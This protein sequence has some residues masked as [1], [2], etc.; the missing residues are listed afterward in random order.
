MSGLDYDTLT[1]G[2]A[3][4]ATGYKRTDLLFSDLEK[5]KRA[6]RKGRIQLIFSGKAHP[7]DDSGRKLIE[8]IFGCTQELKGEIKIV[9]LAN[10]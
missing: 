2:F 10:L 7:R 6:N 8:Q 4:R 3:R 1:V 5:L 9:Y